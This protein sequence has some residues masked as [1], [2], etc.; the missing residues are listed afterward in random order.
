MGLLAR[1]R[2]SRFLRDSATL[3]VA[4]GV[5]GVASLMGAFALAHVLGPTRQGEFYLAVATW[6]FLWFTVNL[7]LSHVA[8]S[9]IAAAAARKNADK[10]GYWIA[11]MLKVSLVLGLLV[12]ALGW[13]ALPAFCRWAYGSEAAGTAAAI[14]ALTPLTAL[15]RVALNSA[16]QGARRMGALARVENGEELTRVFLV[17]GGALATG[18][19]IG[20]AIGTVISSAVGS[21][22]SINA[23]LRECRAK[24]APLPGLSVV[25]A[26]LREVPITHGMRLGL[27]VGLMRNVGTYGI[28]ILPAMMLGIFGDEAWVAFLR[29]SQRFVDVARMIMGGISR[30]ALSHFSGLMGTQNLDRLEKSYWRASLLSGGLMTAGLLLSLP[31]APWLIGFF[32]DRYHEPVWLCYRILVPGV[33]IFSF[34]VA[35]D[36]FYLV[37]NTL[38]AAVV[39]QLLGLVLCTGLTAFFAWMWPTVG[40]A[41]GLSVSF[42]WSVIHVVYAGYWFR[43]RRTE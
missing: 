1:L 35:N 16:L 29:L 36:T 15:P 2:G 33:I 13:L 10:V 37:T 24:V 38:K 34:S 25:R 9:Q 14:L 40:T 6:S 43:S 31:V 41:I 12:G 8:I 17:V 42:A 26:G 21:L 32:P 3:Q 18:D 30:T 23:Y 4:A 7:G 39:L 20:P 27:R 28:Q 5:S 22:L 19:A 11:W